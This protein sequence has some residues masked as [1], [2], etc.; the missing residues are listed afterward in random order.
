MS[1]FQ[2]WYNLVVVNVILYLLRILF[3]L[4]IMSNLNYLKIYY[5]ELKDTIK[6][7]HEGIKNIDKD[8]YMFQWYINQYE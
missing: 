1:I 7:D 2:Y 4:R 6:N 5:N 8:A 3:V